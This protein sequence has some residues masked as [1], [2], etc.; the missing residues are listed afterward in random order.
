MSMLRKNNIFIYPTL[1]L[2][3]RQI[4]LNRGICEYPLLQQFKAILLKL[5]TEQHNVNEAWKHLD[6]KTNKTVFLR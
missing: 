2:V 6:A 3:E 5:M 1:H 4:I